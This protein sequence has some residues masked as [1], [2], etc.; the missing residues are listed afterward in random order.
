MN[1]LPFRY[2]TDNLSYV[3]FRGASAAVV[4]GG[5]VEQIL[6]FLTRSGITLRYVLN[7]HGHADHTKGNARLMAATGAPWANGRDVIENGGV[8]IDGESLLAMATP[9]H[10]ADSVTFH[11]NG[12]LITG[13]TLFNGTVGNCFSGDL[14][15]FY[16][17]I[18]RLSRFPDDT[19]VYAGHDYVHEAMASARY[20]EPNNPDIDGYLARYDTNHVVSTLG[21]ERRVNPYL[22]VNTPV[23]V[24]QIRQRGLPADTALDRWTSFMNMG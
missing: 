10:T 17:S 1:I 22:R 23:I 14:A 20:W 3:V 24:S 5:A 7:T 18:E 2:D 4:D 19:R 13:D 16:D 11:F 12:V 9:G 15:A 6:A 21:E 8:S